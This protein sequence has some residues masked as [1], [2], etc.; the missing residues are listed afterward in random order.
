MPISIK[1]ADEAIDVLGQVIYIAGTQWGDEGKGKLV[2]ILSQKYDVV[3]RAAGGANAGHTICINKDGE[4]KKFVFHLLPSGVLHEDKICVIGNGLV[5]H[6][7]ALLD[8]IHELKEKGIDLKGRL[9]LSDRAHIILNYHREIDRIQEERK[10]DNKVGTTLKGIGPA[11]TDKISRRGIRIGELKN[12]GAFADKLRKNAEFHM[13]EYGFEFDIEKEINIHKD[14][15][16]II[17]S[18]IINTAEYLDKIYKEGKNIL[19]EGAQGAHLDID[20]GTYPF[21]TSSNTTSGGVAT[22]LGIAPNKLNTVIGIAKAYITRVGAGPFPTEL[23]DENG[24]LLRDNGH[25]YGSTT[26]RPRRCGWFDATVVKNANILSGVTSINLTKLDV[27]TGLET[28]KIGVEYKLNG[29]TIN[30]IPSSLEDFEN[31]EVLY[32]EMPGWK[33]DI[34]EVTKFE[35]LPE[36]AQNYVNK[37]EEIIEVPINFIGVGVHRADMIYK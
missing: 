22:G 31:V 21:V 2:D 8:E 7:P 3:A 1:N 17:D 19:T 23:E 29:E 20:H 30:F 33:E 4:S 27:L 5:V 18:M 10:G 13:K 36:N 25:E 24:K 16:G 11:Y 37:L 6:I 12:F 34:S 14:A 9:L 35:D 32:E 26:G 28:I 15:L